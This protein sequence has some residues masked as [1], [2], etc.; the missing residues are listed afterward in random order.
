M[1]PQIAQRF[2]PPQ[3]AGFFY[4]AA[5]PIPTAWRS[6]H[7]VFVLGRV[8]TNPGRI[9]AAAAGAIGS[10]YFNSTTFINSGT[11][12]TLLFGSNSLGPA[13]GSMGGG[14]SFGPAV[15][16]LT[17]TTAVLNKNEAVLRRMRAD[18]AWLLSVFLDDQGPNW[19]GYASFSSPQRES[20]YL[21]QVALAARHRAI[22]DEL[23]LMLI[24]NG[25]WRGDTNYGFP[26]RATYGCS[27]MDS[28]CIEKHDHR[29]EAAFWRT[30]ARGQW[31][32]RDSGGFRGM[33][34]I[35]GPKTGSTAADQ[36][37]RWRVEPDIGWIAEQSGGLYDT[38]PSQATANSL[39]AA[40]DL[41]ITFSGQTP[42][43]T[44]AVAPTS[45]TVQVA[46]TL[47]FTGTA[48][49]GA[50]L[51][52]RV[53]GVAGGNS[54][55]GTISASGLYT[56]PATV[57]AV[58][59]VTISAGVATGESGSALVTVQSSAPPTPDPQPPAVPAANPSADGNRFIGVLKANMTADY[60]R[61]VRVFFDNPGIIT[62]L[63]ALVDGLATSGVGTQ[64]FRYSIYSDTDGAPT[65]L[66]ATTADGS[67]DAGDPPEWQ[68]LALTTP[69]LVPT[70]GTTLHFMLHSGT[71]L[72]GRYYYTANDSVSGGLSDTF[73]GG[74]VASFSGFALGDA[75]LSIFADYT[76]VGVTRARMPLLIDTPGGDGS[77]P[78]LTTDTDGFS[79]VR[80]YVMKFP[81]AALTTATGALQVPLDYGSGGKIRLRFAAAATSGAYNVR[82]STSSQAAGETADASYTNEAYQSVTTPATT[83]FIKDVEFTLTPTISPGDVLTVKVTRDGAGASGTDSLTANLL[84]LGAE[85]DY[86]VA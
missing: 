35:T 24:G 44:V 81:D 34:H 32:M 54:T 39:L 66:L 56:A 20:I 71:N 51:T 37:S 78:A 1:P 65:T 62:H 27:Y 36:T 64:A 13:V 31:G 49:N 16:L 2:A 52:W 26:A 67:I 83:R 15:D 80:R 21:A 7:S 69:L 59:D 50:T 86:T 42:S 68:R 58:G 41:G 74:S 14:T 47:Q 5:A 25:E 75:D 9:E 53:N 29:S 84:L 11:Y 55:V 85:L 33:L 76:P 40:H 4:N 17:N 38:N 79:N 18:H 72:V 70:A 8:V 43:V 82:V 48:S 63:T 45:A 77:F 23:G 10:I 60:N 19:A 46:T 61:G 57:P 22:A 3:L 6:R 12:H 30:V 28:F 73:I